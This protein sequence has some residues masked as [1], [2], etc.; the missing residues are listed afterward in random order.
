MGNVASAVWNH[1]YGCAQD[2]LHIR[3]DGPKLQ[4]DKMI[5]LDAISII[6]ARMSKIGGLDF[7]A[8]FINGYPVG[9]YT[10]RHVP[11]LKSTQILE[12][13]S[14]LASMFHY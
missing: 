5:Y 8:L 9:V 3:G 10:S 13:E 12:Q 1:V 4:D 7:E 14:P 11:R 2:N 6:E